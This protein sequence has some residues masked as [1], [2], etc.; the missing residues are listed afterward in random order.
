MHKKPRHYQQQQQPWNPCYLNSMQ[1][2][3]TIT[4]SSQEKGNHSMMAKNGPAEQYTRDKNP[5][6]NRRENQKRETI[7]GRIKPNWRSNER[8]PLRGG[9]NLTQT[10]RFW[11]RR[12]SLERGNEMQRGREGRTHPRRGSCRKRTHQSSGAR[13][14]VRDETKHTNTRTEARV[15]AP[16]RPFALGLELKI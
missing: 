9:T 6:E 15:L 10:R 3:T 8:F 7:T 11:T 16:S 1:R 2:T 13:N 4:T 5:D 14:L 12:G